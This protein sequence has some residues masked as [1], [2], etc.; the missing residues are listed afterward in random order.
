ML[1][2]CLRMVQKALIGLL[3]LFVFLGSLGIPLYEHTCLHEKMSIKTLFKASD[4]CAVKA[5]DQH[6]HPTCCAKASKEVVKDEC[7]TEEMTY[8]TM[9]FNFFEFT[10]T[11]ISLLPQVPFTYTK[12]QLFSSI[13]LSNEIVLFATNPDPPSLSGKDLLP[14]NCI[15]RL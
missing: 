14:K 4:H 13:L 6:Q 11:P 7:C 9:T 2:I 1:Y 15:W 12:E 5:S 3:V 10:D 8:L